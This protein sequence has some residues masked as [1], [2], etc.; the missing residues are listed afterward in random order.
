MKKPKVGEFVVVRKK[1]YLVI[2]AEYDIFGGTIFAAYQKKG[3]NRPYLDSPFDQ[4]SKFSELLSRVKERFERMR[5]TRCEVFL[6]NHGVNTCTIKQDE[7]G[8]DGE[9]H[10]SSHG[11]DACDNGL[12][13]NVYECEGYSPK[14]K[15]VVD[16]GDICHECICYFYN[17]DDSLVES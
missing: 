4:D 17:G 2:M 15:E 10:F 5:S 7:D 11:C 16:L 1:P 12:G 8:N 6:K 3:E 9:A 13:N 14:K